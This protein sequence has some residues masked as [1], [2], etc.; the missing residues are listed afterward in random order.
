MPDDTTPSPP[1]LDL[2]EIAPA[3]RRPGATQ[4]KPEW[5]FQAWLHRFLECVVLSPCEVRGFDKASAA[6]ARIETRMM[7]MGRGVKDGSPDHEVVQG[8][9]L[10][11]VKFECK[12]GTG[13]PTP[14]QIGTANAYERCGVTVARECRSIHQALDALRRGGVRLHGNADNLAVHYQAE[15]EAA[16]RTLELRKVPGA[17]KKKGSSRPFRPKP[18]RSAVAA[19]NRFNAIRVGR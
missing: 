2:G 9:P 17:A 8:F 12:A 19:G 14:A 11:V 1:W 6:F 10:V 3:K 7:A 5:S 16:L 13:Q 15:V 4:R 18:S